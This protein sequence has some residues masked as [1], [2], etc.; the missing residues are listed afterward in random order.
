LYKTG[1]SYYVK[2]KKNYS[3][4]TQYYRITALMAYSRRIAE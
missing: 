3:D 1:Y 2:A 4:N